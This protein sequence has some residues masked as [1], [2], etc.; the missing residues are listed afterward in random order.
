MKPQHIAHLFTF[1]TWLW[2]IVWGT[3]SWWQSVHQADT[4]A[5]WAVMGGVVSV[6][7]AVAQYG[8]AEQ[9]HN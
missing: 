9:H 6:I 1:I 4:A 5:L 7:H 2:V 3:T 8:I